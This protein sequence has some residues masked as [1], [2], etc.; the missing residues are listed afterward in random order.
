MAAACCRVS[1]RFSL[2]LLLSSAPLSRLVLPPESPLI[3]ASRKPVI[4]EIPTVGPRGHRAGF[5]S[6]TIDGNPESVGVPGSVPVCVAHELLRAGHRYLDVRTPEEFG[7]GHPVGAANIPY[8]WK[9]GSGMMK[10]QKFLEEV[11]S[12]FG[13][14]DKIIVGCRSGKRSLMAATDLMSAG[15]TGV[16]DVA[17]GYSAWMQN[18]LPSE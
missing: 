1:S 5:G 2:S 18:G 17:G 12:I 11:S 13:K 7:A 10:N 15:F 4:P 3:S 6:S 9:V 16:T 8:M 14:D